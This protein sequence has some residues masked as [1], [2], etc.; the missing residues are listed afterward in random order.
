[1]K[2]FNKHI[3]EAVNRGIRLALD[4]YQDIEDN[5]SISSKS[6]VIRND[7]TIRQRVRFNFL[8]KKFLNALKEGLEI[9]QAQLRCIPLSQEIYDKLDAIVL[10]KKELDELV[11]LSKKTGLKYNVKNDAFHLKDIIRYV[12]VINPKADLNWIDVSH[13]TWMRNIFEK[14]TFNGDISEWDVSN[15]TDMQELF[16]ES[17]FNGNLTKWDVSNVTNM[18]GIF[19]HSKF[20]QPIEMW[21]ISKVRC[22]VSMFAYSPFNQPLN[23]WNFSNVD[24]A[25]Y[26]FHFAQKFNQDI[27]D[28]DVSKVNNFNAMFRCA[29]VFNQDLN[30]WNDKIHTDET[31]IMFYGCNID[32]KNIPE[33]IKQNGHYK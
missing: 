1:M 7:E 8:L 16:K 33:K 11:F 5:S 9:E 13:M 6:D 32:E 14:S 28:W 12:T 19:E 23:R 27:S 25:C 15:V 31:K 21:D 2:R 18:L 29:T 22:T 17:S 10:S 20:N 3:L 30:K 26:M 4:D 24:N